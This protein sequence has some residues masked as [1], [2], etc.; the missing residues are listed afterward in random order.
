VQRTTGELR[1]QTGQQI[2]AEIDRHSELRSV[3]SNSG[4]LAYSGNG[5]S[6]ISEVT[7]DI[8]HR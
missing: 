8:E 5:G 6:R 3:N 2:Q 7:L 4:G 1:V